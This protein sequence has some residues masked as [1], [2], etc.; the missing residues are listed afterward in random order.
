MAGKHFAIV[1][2]GLA[3][4]AAIYNIARDLPPSRETVLNVTVI[5]PNAGDEDWGL[6][7]AY[8]TPGK[9]NVKTGAMGFTSFTED[10]HPWLKPE[11][12]LT[13]LNDPQGFVA[14]QEKKKEQARKNGE[15]TIEFE[16]ITPKLDA[17]GNIPEESKFSKD[18][19]LPRRLYGLYIG[20]VRELVKEYAEDRG[21]QV[22]F[23]QAQ[24]I[25]ADMVGNDEAIKITLSNGETVTADA[26]GLATG[27]GKILSR[28]NAPDEKARE[29]I[30]QNPWGNIPHEVKQE[31]KNVVMLG[32]GATTVDKIMELDEAGF[33]KRGG[34]VTC[35]S[36]HA[37]LPL[38]HAENI[39]PVSDEFKKDLAALKKKA[40]NYSVTICSICEETRHRT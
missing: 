36:N 19:Y 5:G 22:K 15:E 2:D 1:G 37:F 31:A 4:V 26:L 6:G 14:L 3:S 40:R 38:S 25:D 16:D 39:K 29:R 11:G 9:L 23:E 34:K 18:S 35:L 24:A 20:S 27:N 21:V 7:P 12:F 8:S 28:V 33:F 32:T 30:M 10:V 17:N 13:W